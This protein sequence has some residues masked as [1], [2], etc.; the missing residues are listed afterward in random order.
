MY[1]LG[2]SFHPWRNAK[3]I[4]DGAAILNYIRETAEAYGIDRQIRFGHQVRRAM[5]SSADA[6]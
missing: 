1:T 3:A 5:W 2:Y 4:A 6:M